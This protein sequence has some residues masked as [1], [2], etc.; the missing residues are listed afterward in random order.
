M[1][2]QILI[3][4]YPLA[5]VFCLGVEVIIDSDDRILKWVLRILGVLGILITTYPLWGR[6]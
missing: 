1:T 5:L 3:E 4:L 2:E 6:S